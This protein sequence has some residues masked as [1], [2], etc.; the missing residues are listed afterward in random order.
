MEVR[1]SRRG[2]T[3]ASPCSLTA[4]SGAEAQSL[5][6]GGIISASIAFH[7]TQLGV[8]PLVIERKGVGCAASG[9]AGG[10]LARSW[11]D[12]SCTQEVRGLFRDRT[13]KKK[14]K[15][16]RDR[17]TLVF[18]SISSHSSTTCRMTSTSRWPSRSTSRVIE[19]SG[20]SLSA[21][22]KR[23]Q[24]VPG[25]RSRALPTGSTGISRGAYDLVVT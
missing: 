10:F 5:C 11:G 21:R 3:P 15:K 14:K 7:L 20:P 25:G 24:R 19:R 18:H 6:V 4:V 12:G 1:T 17:S 8:K 9:K 2:R 23:G 22:R 13:K 16:F